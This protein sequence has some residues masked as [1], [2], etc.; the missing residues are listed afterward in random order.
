MS[1]HQARDHQRMV[2]NH[3]VLISLSSG[4][5]REVIGFRKIVLPLSEDTLVPLVAPHRILCELP[6]QIEQLSKVIHPSTLISHIDYTTHKFQKNDFVETLYI[7]ESPSLYHTTDTHLRRVLQNHLWTM[8]PYDKTTEY[9]LS[10]IET[11]TLLRTPLL[12][13]SCEVYTQFQL[14]KLEEYLNQKNKDLTPDHIPEIIRRIPLSLRP[15][16]LVQLSK[17]MSAAIHTLQTSDLKKTFLQQFVRNYAATG[18]SWTELE[19]AFKQTVLDKEWSE[20]LE[21]IFPTPV[22]THEGLRRALDHT[23]TA[24]MGLLKMKEFLLSANDADA[25]KKGV[26]VYLEKY[27][28]NSLSSLPDI[29]SRVRTWSMNENITLSF[30]LEIYQTFSKKGIEEKALLEVF[31][32]YHS[33]LDIKDPFKKV[34]LSLITQLTKKEENMEIPS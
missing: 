24:D 23:T 4:R 20:L 7:V 16:H 13:L 10:H 30:L 19:K 28:E 11:L 33:P 2:H 6:I 22:K 5:L 31:D 29:L 3:N 12:H 9:S 14:Q 32:Q 18:V 34:L 27:S 26:D 21:E 8:F 17:M 1:L 15:E 25:L